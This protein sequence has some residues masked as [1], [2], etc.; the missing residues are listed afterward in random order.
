M[1]DEQLLPLT[2]ALGS[3][4]HLVILHLALLPSKEDVR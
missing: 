1:G 4:R 2:F 3:V